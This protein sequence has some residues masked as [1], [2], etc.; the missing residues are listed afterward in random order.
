MQCKD[1]YKGVCR[2]IVYKNYLRE[3][4]KPCDKIRPVTKADCIREMSDEELAEWFAK[5]QIA[6]VAE[7]LKIAHI[8]WEQSPDLQKLTAKECLE[9]LRQPVEDNDYDL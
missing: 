7:A 5:T 8:P 9:W 6:N 2:N 1:E 4:K 3:C